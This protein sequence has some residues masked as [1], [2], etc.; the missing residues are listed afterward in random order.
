MVVNT[1]ADLNNLNPSNKDAIYVQS[2]N[3]CYVH[4]NAGESK[5]CILC[6]RHLCGDKHWYIDNNIYR[7]VYY[8]VDDV[9]DFEANNA[10]DI[11]TSCSE[12]QLSK[13]V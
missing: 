10:T 11:T 3:Q 12:Y 2:E 1:L 6:H 4:Y 8:S 7:G 13:L 9:Y 5:Y